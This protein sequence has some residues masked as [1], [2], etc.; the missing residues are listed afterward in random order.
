M[1]QKVI[2]VPATKSSG[3]HDPDAMKSIVNRLRRAEGQLH[4]LIAMIGPEANCREVVTQLAAVSK[5]LDRAGF[6]IISNAMRD[7]VDGGEHD[8]MDAKE[9]ERL[10][11]SL[12]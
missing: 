2:E 9:L 1:E 3:G 12:A 7:C 11:L 10:F 4:A 5:A 6:A 8:Q